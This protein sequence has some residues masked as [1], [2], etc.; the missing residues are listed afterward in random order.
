MVDLLALVRAV[1]TDA[2]V[3][4]VLSRELTLVRTNAAWTRFALANGGQDCVRRWRPGTPMLDAIPDVLRPFYVAA[5]EKVWATGAR[6][7]HDYECSSAGVF[8]RFRMVVYPV[9][10]DFLVV[11]N[12]LLVETS[13]TRQAHL[14]RDAMYAVDGVI[15]ICAH[16][17]RV[18]NPGLA[19]RWDWVPDYLA[20]PPPNLSHGLCPPC[21]EFHYA[22]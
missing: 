21:M 16:C 1:S 9:Q 13:H 7:E 14:A 3:S 5:Y 20:M 6:W 19:A 10:T 4:Y 2:D 12:S 15:T 17:R 22:G 8:R 18:R 11:T